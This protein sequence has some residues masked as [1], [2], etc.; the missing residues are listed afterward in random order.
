M[1]RETKPGDVVRTDGGV[2]RMYYLDSDSQTKMRCMNLFYA[3]SYN[4]NV[5]NSKQSDS[6]EFIFNMKDVIGNACADKP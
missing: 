3:E 1:N 6:E 2:Y 4:D 5:G